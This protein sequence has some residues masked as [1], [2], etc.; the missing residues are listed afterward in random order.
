MPSHSSTVSD[1]VASNDF[2]SVTITAVPGYV[3]D[4]TNFSIRLSRS[5]QGPTN[6]AVRSSADGFTADLDLW[7]SGGTHNR[8]VDVNI[9][10][11]SSVEFRLYG[12]GAPAAGGVLRVA[13]GGSFGAAGI[14]VAIFGSVTVV[15]EPG[16]LA[17]F[18]S[19]LGM[20]AYTRRRRHLP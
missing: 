7:T 20:A 9:S 12:F 3:L 16:T 5:N 15:P 13:D 6:F 19:G 1:A 11:Q 18:L 17:L 14:D 4:I 8:I 2:Y 10:G